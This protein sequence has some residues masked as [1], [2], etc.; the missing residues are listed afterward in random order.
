MQTSVDY[1]A[2]A[3]NMSAFEHR[4]VMSFLNATCLQFGL[5]LPN[6]PPALLST[7]SLK[8]LTLTDYQ[9]A[10]LT[11]APEP[12]LG[13][14]QVGWT[15]PDIIAS[16]MLN[17]CTG[18]QCNVAANLWLTQTG[19]TPETSYVLLQYPASF[20]KGGAEEQDIYSVFQAFSNG[21]LLLLPGL[22]SSC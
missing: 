7:Y 14:V 6:T 17:S 4:A 16:H 8:L 20:Q 21:E 13:D 15:S 22:Y 2:R 12:S 5:W 11:H 3:A 9:A 18:D 10:I 1:V 19:L